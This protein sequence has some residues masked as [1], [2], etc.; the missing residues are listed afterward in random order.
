[1]QLLAEKLV[2]QEIAPGGISLGT[3]YKILKKSN[4][5]LGCG[6]CARAR[7]TKI[8]IDET[9]ETKLIA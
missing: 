6:S 8:K 5:D 9:F 3:V 4:L 1:V 2:E 7:S